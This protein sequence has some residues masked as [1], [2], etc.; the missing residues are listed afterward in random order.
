MGYASFHVVHDSLHLG[1]SQVISSFAILIFS[2]SMSVLMFTVYVKML[3]CADFMI[4]NNLF[5]IWYTATLHIYR[6]KI[7]HWLSKNDL[8]LA[9]FVQL[10]E[11]SVFIIYVT[12][13][14]NE[15]S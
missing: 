9:S 6:F 11:R 7:T 14:Q 5:I 15:G 10:Y 3:P 4:A 1:I 8:L 12:F 2:L 13:L